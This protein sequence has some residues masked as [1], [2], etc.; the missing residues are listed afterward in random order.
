MGNKSGERRCCRA[1]ITYTISYRN[2]FVSEQLR[3]VREELKQSNEE[4][5]TW[6]QKYEGK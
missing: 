6:K 3:I 2:E 4:L 5:E 1:D